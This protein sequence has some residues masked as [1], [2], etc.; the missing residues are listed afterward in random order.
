MSSTQ[1]WVGML[2]PPLVKWASPRLKK[3]F[4]LEEFDTKT[5]S[6]ITTKQYPSY[7]AFFYAL[8]ILSLLSTG[9]IGLFLIM[10]YVPEI[11]PGTSYTVSLWLGLVNM[12][13][14]WFIAGALLDSIYW[15][16]SPP[17]FRD[18]VLLR[19]L[20]EGW[21]YDIKQQIIT[22]VKIGV[23]YYL[24]MLPLILFLLFM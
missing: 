23:V 12:I 13:G 2:V 22:L 20:K 8:W 17:N 7:Y 24:V 19:Q 18:Y 5:R 3:F 14:I 21:G 16:I 4:K 9:I 1:F 6:R 11:I 10:I 15:L